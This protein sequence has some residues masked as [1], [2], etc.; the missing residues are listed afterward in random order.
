MPIPKPNAGEKQSD[1][2]SRCMGNATMKDEY[3]DNDQRL[4][5]CFSSFRKGPAENI[6]GLVFNAFEDEEQFVENALTHNSK[7]ADR[8][9]GWGSVDKTKLPYQAHVWQAPGTERDKKSTWKYPHHWVSGGSVGEDGVYTSGTMYLSKSG[10]NAA[11]AAAMGA[12]TGKRAPA[13]V[14]AHLKRHRNAIGIEENTQRV[15]HL[16]SNLVRQEKLDGVPHWVCPTVM[17]LEGVHN[18][19]LY[20][21]SEIAK[22]P[23]AWNGRPVL[24]DH[25]VDANGSPA[26]A[27]SPEFVEKQEVGRLFNSSFEEET[28]RLKAEAWINIQ[29]CQKVCPELLQ[30]IASDS[31]VE[32][33][34]GLFTELD[35]TPGEWN[36]EE[37]IGRVYNFRPDHLALL[38]HD[39][40]ACSWDDGAGLMRNARRKADVKGGEKVSVFGKIFEGLKGRLGFAS[41]ELSHSDI[42]SLLRESVRASLDPNPLEN[43]HVWVHSVFDKDF[44]YEVENNDGAKLYRQGYAVTADEKTELVGDR[45][46]VRLSTEFVPVANAENETGGPVGQGE[47]KTGGSGNMDRAAQVEALIANGVWVEEDR[48]FLMELT[49]ERFEKLGLDKPAA[50]SDDDPPK[51]DPKPEEKPEEGTPTEESKPEESKPDENR[52]ATL[53]ELLENATGDLKETIQEAT[54]HH[55]ASKAAMVAALVKNENC[56]IPEAEL[57]EMSIGRLRS[58]LKLAGPEVVGSDVGGGGMFDMSTP[59][60]VQ[61]QGDGVPDM[62]KFNWDKGKKKDAA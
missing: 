11:W 58:L 59:A 16:M 42:H 3:P 29:K 49:D 20:E 31:E 43:E 33:S 1:F 57:K 50:N 4:A 35:P 34:T 21:E 40:G 32:V 37:F 56:D 55:S 18:G 6:E 2:I 36:G 13:A 10:L 7:L 38:P 30:M 17:L 41:N 23:S 54:A 12:R 8:E 60:P 19:L 52:A 53:D 51:E 28:G 5:V 46:E 48:A 26:T 15:R 62:P 9:P 27:G 22:F 25:S 44:V 45:V 39:K 47:P 14:I 61:N 24:V